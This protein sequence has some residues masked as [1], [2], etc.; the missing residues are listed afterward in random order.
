MRK[1]RGY[2]LLI[3]IG[4]L[5]G[6]LAVKVEPEREPEYGG[7][8]LSE[9]VERYK[10]WHGYGPEGHEA[11]IAIDAIGMKAFPYLLKW[12]TYRQ[13]AWKRELYHTL[14]LTDKRIARSAQAAFALPILRS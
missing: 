6:V 4:V 12:A 2:L 3:A 13:P 7:K 10:Y 9:W 8:R 1:R 14:D 5:V 11:A